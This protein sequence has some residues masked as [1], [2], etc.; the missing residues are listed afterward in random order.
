M[1]DIAFSHAEFVRLIKRFATDMPRLLLRH[2]STAELAL[3]F[4]RLNLLDIFHQRFTV[5]IIGQMKVGKSTL[6][7]ALI[8]KDLA[9]VGVIET[10]ATVNWFRYSGNEP[11]DM[12]RVHWRD[13]SSEDIHISEDNHI[14]EINKWVSNPKNLQRIKSIEFFAQTDFLQTANVVDTPGTRSVHRGHEDTVRGFLLAEELERESLEYGGRADAIIYVV[15]PLG[16]ETDRDLLTLFGDKTRPPGASAANSIAVVQKWEHLENPFDNIQ[17]KCERLL[18]EQLAGKVA[19]VIPTS[20]LLARLSSTVPGEIWELLI[21]LVR[22]SKP[23][24]LTRALKSE[25]QFAM[26]RDDVT[27]NVEELRKLLKASEEMWRV[28][29]LC[30][31][32]IQ[33]NSDVTVRSLPELLYKKS[34][35]GK[36]QKALEER[37]FSRSKLIKA[38]AI[39]AKTRIPCATAIQKLGNLIEGKES[40]LTKGNNCLAQTKSDKP[41]EVSAYLEET[42]DLLQKELDE[43]TTLGKEVDDL[44]Y[45]IERNFKSFDEDEKAIELLQ[46]E[47]DD[48]DKD[49]LAELRALFGIYGLEPFRRLSLEPETPI[50]QVIETAEECL[51]KWNSRLHNISGTS[52]TLARAAVNRLDELLNYLDTPEVACQ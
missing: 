50:S 27:L 21:R 8:E 46:N 38:N 48:L 43:L 22:E 15:N 10:T 16:R 30:V 4:D 44:K 40:L 24:G 39:M 11:K 5:A 1:N 33:Q 52:E 6:I 26:D 17:K 42:I 29:P 34:G 32:I 35:V 25:Q 45:V 2:G 3:Q 37:F 13:G 19:D 23:D 14:S 47:T 12:F 36:L 41:D 9:P 31:F 7:N 18:D 49:D 51:D 28:I 20:S